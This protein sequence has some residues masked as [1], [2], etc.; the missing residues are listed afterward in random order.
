M[1]LALVVGASLL[2][3]GISIKLLMGQYPVLDF[4]PAELT[5]TNKD[6]TPSP[7]IPAYSRKAHNVLDIADVKVIDISYQFDGRHDANRADYY[8]NNIIPDGWAKVESELTDNSRLIWLSDHSGNSAILQ[9]WYEANGQKSGSVGVYKRNRIK[10]AL[11]LDAKSSLRWQF[12][13]CSSLR[14]QDEAQLLRQLLNE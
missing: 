9:Y 1:P 3:S 13:R 11:Q 10:Q 12:V 7:Y 4:S 5:T 8:L 2:A 6:Q 14:C